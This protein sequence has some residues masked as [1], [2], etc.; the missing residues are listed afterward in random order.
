MLLALWKIV[1]DLFGTGMILFLVS[2]LL[3]SY[4]CVGVCLLPCAIDDPVWLNWKWKRKRLVATPFSHSYEF[5][6]YWKFRLFNHF[7]QAKVLFPEDIWLD[8]PYQGSYLTLS[9]IV[10][11]IQWPSIWVVFSLVPIV[12]GVALAS[13]TE[14]SF[15]WY[16]NNPWLYKGIKDSFSAEKLKYVSESLTWDAE[17]SFGT[18]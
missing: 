5:C 10:L 15:N 14:A 11:C 7:F 2:F 12:G 13:F 1:M 18:G 6:V 9:L 8:N 17:F 16:N 3:Y 4:V